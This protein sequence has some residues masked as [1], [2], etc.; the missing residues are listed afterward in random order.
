MTIEP[1]LMLK[2]LGSKVVEKIYDDGLSTP[3][4]ETSKLITYFIKTVQL[5][6]FPLQMT[7]ALQDRLEKR[8]KVAVE[9]V[10]EANRI[11]PPSSILLPIISHLSYIEDTN[12]LANLY[13]NLLAKAMDKTR[14]SEAH[15]GFIITISQ[16]SPDEALLL[17]EL[18]FNK[19]KFIRLADFDNKLRKFYNFR[20][21]SNEFPITKLI[22]S[23]NFDMY[24]GHLE[25]LDLI[26]VSDK[27]SE[28]IWRDGS[29]NTE[30]I[31][32]RE[33]YTMGFT[34]FGDL[35]K[36]AC[37]PDNESVL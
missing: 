14:N 16:L 18:K 27:Q 37:L 20:M 9:Q 13:Q 2:A 32:T 8:L 24:L 31:G 6:C 12:I 36:S 19:F 33:T 17:Y 5:F 26:C 23:N 1:D 22:F 35:F 3:L 11:A 28:T 25:K 7:A 34:K 29:N 15:P 10:P 4:K 30:Q 21:E